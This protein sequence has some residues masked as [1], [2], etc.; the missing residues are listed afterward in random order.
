MDHLE[1]IITIEGRS[2]SVTACINGKRIDVGFAL[3]ASRDGWLAEL[4]ED[5]FGEMVQWKNPMMALRAIGEAALE[6]AAKMFAAHPEATV[7]TFSGSDAK[8]CAVY[9][10]LLR[11]A[12][13]RSERYLFE[14]GDYVPAI[15]R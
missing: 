11:R 6:N 13:I 15:R 3:T 9:E 5:P 14:D 4:V 8:R 12:G 10:K 7:A 2:V 1:N